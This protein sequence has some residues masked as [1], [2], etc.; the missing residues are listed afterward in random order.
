MPP[1]AERR[2]VAG[3]RAR[4]S[5][6]AA[7]PP[8]RPRRAELQSALRVVLVTP[9]DR[10]AAQIVALV[11]AA[12]PGG[13]TAV[14]LR[15]PALDAAARL[16][17]CVALRAVTEATGA[18][19]LV[20]RDALAAAAAGA[21]GV[22]L[23]HGGPTLTQ[24]RRARPDWILGRSCHWPPTREDLAADWVTLSPFASTPRSHPRPL[25]GEG[26]AAAVLAAPGLGPCVA[27]GGLRAADVPRLPAG[28]A[29]VAALRAFSAVPDP[30]GAARALRAAVD[31]RCQEHAVF[32][33]PRRI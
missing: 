11:A 22:Q 2:T 27:L 15:E 23:G 21:D 14:L 18:L 31:R 7:V 9:G 24:L 16:Q 3:R 25:L 13:V 8:G 6:P 29:G 17:L 30:A 28:L 4:A 32:G 19:L 33:P 10:P 20:S 26:Q 12:L 1:A 5:R